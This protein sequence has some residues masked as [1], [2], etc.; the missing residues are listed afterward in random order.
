MT[1]YKRRQSVL[2]LLRSQPG[3]RVPEIA[4]ALGVSEGTVRNDLNALETDGQLVRVHGGALLNELHQNNLTAF[5]I[6]YKD[7]DPEKEAIAKT[8]ASLVADGD[9]LLLDASSTAFHFALKLAGRQRLRVVTNGIDVARLLAQNSS[10]TVILIGGV[11]NPDG[12]SVTGLMSQEIIAELHIQKAFVSC[13]GFSVE[14]G[15]TE[16]HFEEAQLKR[17]AIESAQ[18]VFALVDSSKLG[19]EDLTPVAQPLQIK[20]LFTDYGISDEWKT[21]LGWANIPFTVCGLEIDQV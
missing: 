20:H 9:S 3:L 7:H 13:S 10:N 4:N 21:R 14:R 5:N 17:K 12:S 16:V 8:A 18:Q 19:H 6:R 2:E 11:M 1:A 15:M